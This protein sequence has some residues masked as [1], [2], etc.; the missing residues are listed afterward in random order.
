MAELDDGLLSM[1]INSN[2]KHIYDQDVFESQR[3]TKAVNGI[4]EASLANNL[5]SMQTMQLGEAA[6]MNSVIRNDLAPH[7]ATLGA[8]VASLRSFL[9]GVVVSPGS[10]SQT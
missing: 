2:A 5:K 7:L 6:A 9:A 4:L 1:M 10:G 8:S 3:N